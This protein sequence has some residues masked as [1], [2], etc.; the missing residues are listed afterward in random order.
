MSKSKKA[1]KNID[2]EIINKLMQLSDIDSDY[3][4]NSIESGKI[5]TYTAG[6]YI[7]LLKKL[8]SIERLK[9]SF[10]KNSSMRK[11]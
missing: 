11:S 1:K 10:R 3:L 6:Y 2:K 5:N 9:K 4:I 7:L 8:D